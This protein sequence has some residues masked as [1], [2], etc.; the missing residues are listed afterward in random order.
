MNMFLRLLL[1]HL[2]HHDRP[3]PPPHNDNPP[4]P[5]PSPP[6]RFF[7]DSEDIMLRS[8]HLLDLSMDVTERE[9]K[10]KYRSLARIYHPDKNQCEV[11]GLSQAEATAHFQSIN[12]AY[13]FLLSVL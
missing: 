1:L 13:S 5:P 7:N 12:N 4:S 10:R 2:R 9:L 6:R 3:P 11:T 8:L